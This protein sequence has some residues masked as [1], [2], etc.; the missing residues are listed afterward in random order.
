M[1]LR[2]GGIQSGIGIEIRIRTNSRRRLGQSNKEGPVSPVFGVFSL[3]RAATTSCRD[4]PRSPVTGSLLCS[5]VQPGN[6]SMQ[7]SPQFKGGFMERLL[8]RFRPKVKL[9]A[10]GSTAAEGVLDE[11]GGN[12]RLPPSSP[13]S[14]HGPRTWLPADRAAAWAPARGSVRETASEARGLEGGVIG[15]ERGQRHN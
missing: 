8:D 13:W 5:L 14:G 11:I 4:W 2:G 10:G 3:I 6:L 12:T 7:T 9:V 15:G 1:A